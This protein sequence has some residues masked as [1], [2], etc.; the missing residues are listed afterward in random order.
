LKGVLRQGD[1]A[2]GKLLDAGKIQRRRRLGGKVA[3]ADTGDAEGGREAERGRRQRVRQ[4]RVLHLVPELDLPEAG[5]GPGAQP[6]VHLGVAVAGADHGEREARASPG[7]RRASWARGRR[8]G[9]P[10]R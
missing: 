3:V 6:A 8:A 4:R 2:Q 1:P 7:G 9:G 5:E 10:G